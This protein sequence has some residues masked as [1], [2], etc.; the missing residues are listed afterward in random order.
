MYKLFATGLA[1]L[2]VSAGAF[3]GGATDSGAAESSTMTAVTSGGYSEAP[4]LAELVAAGQLPP[5]AE[6]LPVEPPVMEPIDSVGTYGDTIYVFVNSTE[7]WNTLQEETERGSY[8]AYI[9]ADTTVTPNLAKG[10]E[11]APD[12]KSRSEARRVR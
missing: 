3:A 5:V 12:F 7:P 10:F 1:L 4:M 9:R 2:M 6:R 8:L 11:L